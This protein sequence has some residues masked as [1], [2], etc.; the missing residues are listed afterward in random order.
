[1]D[2]ASVFD[3]D[4]ATGELRWRDRLREH[5]ATLRG[6]KAFQSRCAGK[7]TGFLNSE[8]YLKVRPGQ[9]DYAAH[10]LVWFLAKGEWPDE[11]DHINGVKSDNRLSNLRPVSHAE[12]MGN[13][14]LYAT[15]RSTQP[16]VCWERAKRLW[17]ARIPVDGK[18][19]TLGRSKSLARAVELRRAAETRLGYHKNHGRAI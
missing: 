19:V 17:V 16:G 11:I 14:R 13:K 12:N 7:R 15:N 1:M 9:K 2:F 18:L 10:R 3:C 8:G 5:F 6:W 4:F